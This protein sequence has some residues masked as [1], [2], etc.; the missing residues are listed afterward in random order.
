MIIVTETDFDYIERMEFLSTLSRKTDDCVIPTTREVVLIPEQ[1]AIYR[2]TYVDSDNTQ[3]KSNRYVV[4]TSAQESVTN[5]SVITHQTVFLF[6]ITG[7][8]QSVINSVKQ[9]IVPVMNRLKEEAI[10]AVNETVSNSNTFI[11]NFEIAVVGYRDFCD[12]KHFETH[13]FTSEIS[14]IEEFLKSLEAVGGGDEPEDVKGAFVHALFGISD[15]AT[16]LSWKTDTASKSVYL[17]TDAPAH[18]FAFHSSTVIGDNHSNDNEK[19]WETILLNM[20]LNEIMFNIIKINDK[21][22]KMCDKFRSMCGIA[23]LQYMEIDISQQI[24]HS[25]RS[26]AFAPGRDDIHGP[27][28]EHTLTG[29]VE[30][31]MSSMYRMTSA[32]YAHRTVSLTEPFGTTLVAEYSEPS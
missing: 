7:S 26:R 18:G 21:T 11:L 19:E 27:H 14:E 10:K 6:D 23:E 13:N 5:E 3:P 24:S 30:A 17:I 8:M 9:E 22:T 16:K 25:Y 29:D 32:G 28:E 1:L 15:K 4:T 20:K 31:C 12:Q 2:G